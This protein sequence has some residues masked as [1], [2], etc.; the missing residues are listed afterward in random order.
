MNSTLDQ[1]A[2]AYGIAPF[3]WS[4]TGEQRTVA[5]ATKRALL[6][7]M[8]IPAGTNAEVAASL[9][10]LPADVEAHARAEACFLPEWLREGRCWGVSCQLY[11]LVSGRNHGIG[12]FEDLA[13]L[14]EIAAR[15]GADFV[16]VNPLHALFWSQ[17][18][19]SSPYSPSARQFLNPLYIAIDRV[20]GVDAVV[21]EGEPDPRFIDYVQVAH[22][23][24]RALEEAFVRRPPGAAFRRFVDEGGK[25]LAAFATFEAL[26]EAMSARGLGAG[27]HGWPGD[28]KHCHSSVVVEFA[29]QNAKRVAFF[30]WLQW[31]A[32]TQLAEAEAR[33]RAAGMRIGLYL[34]LA[35]GV[36]PDGM[37]TWADPDLV[38][39]GARIGA[40]PDVFNVAGQD[41]GL[42]PLSPAGLAQR[43]LAPFA[44]DI[45]AAMRCAG[46]L[47]IDHAM[48]LQRLFWIPQDAT[49][50]DGSYVRYP[51]EAMLRTLSRLSHA[52]RA[53]VIG[54]DL[55]TVPE[56]FRE[57]MREAQV[58][59]YRVMQFERDHDGT[60]LSPAAYPREA[61]AC[62]ATHDLPTQHGWWTGHDIDLRERLGLL[63]SQAADQA[64]EERSR[65]RGRLLDA[66]QAAGALEASVREGASASPDLPPVVAVGTH[67]YIARTPCR[68]MVAQIEDLVGE[69]EPVN[70]PGTFLEYPNWRKR[71]SLAL[72]DLASHAQFTAVTR[73]IAAERPR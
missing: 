70:L 12:D 21:P 10:A 8:G 25:A 19:R 52:Y 59:G 1:L 27:W 47:R 32:V 72:E 51:L 5:D 23:K 53:V 6:T 36:A 38:I 4:E 61:L 9:L 3:Y 14:G 66:L 71:M 57:R 16:G 34:D 42:A 20:D 17:P 54:E 18:E 26:S 15:A 13:K 31:L 73:A 64:R 2:Q 30:S 62:F 67:V 44:R 48:A 39:A 22:L 24:R 55:G 69:L 37:A 45:D 63:T 68:L 28:Y 35:V 56:G 29:R 33:A 43:D 58:Q 40:P 60:F 50:R 41:W 11:G 7:A 46:A 65:A 49:A